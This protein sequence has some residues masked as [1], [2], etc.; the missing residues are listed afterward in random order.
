LGYLG[1]AEKAG[2]ELPEF[3]KAMKD[4]QAEAAKTE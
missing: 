1:A 4:A 2:L 3:E